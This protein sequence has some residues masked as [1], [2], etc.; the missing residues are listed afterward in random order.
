[1]GIRGSAAEE[2]LKE[3]LDVIA[4]EIDGSLKKK[5]EQKKDTLNA[6]ISDLK[7]ILKRV[8]GLEEMWSIIKASIGLFLSYEQQIDFYANQI[9]ARYR[10]LD[11]LR[12]EYHSRGCGE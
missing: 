9:D 11:N 3:I 4:G 1:M 7:R 10:K 12:K 8:K 6:R 2:A 5:Y